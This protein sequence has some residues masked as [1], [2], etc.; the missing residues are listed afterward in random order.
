MRKYCF[1]IFIIISFHSFSQIIAVSGNVQDSISKIPVKYSTVTALR[2]KDLVLIKMTQTNEK[3]YFLLNNI[4]HVNP[5]QIIISAMG[6][7]DKLI[8]IPMN[9]LNKVIDFDTILLSPKILQLDEV[10]IY[11]IKNAVYY[12]HDTLNF[13]ADSFK[14]RQNANVEDLL[15][16]LPGI[17][18]NNQGKITSQGS[19][20]DKVLV[21]GDEFFGNDATIATR[22]L[23]ANGIESIQ[24]YEKKDDTNF[25][26]DGENL[27]IINLKLK[28]SAKN[29]GFG[30]VTGASDFKKFYEGT[31]FANR[32][33]HVEKSAIFLAG[34]N[35]PNSIYRENEIYK[36]AINENI[37]NDEL[38][39]DEDWN[40]TNNEQQKEGISKIF[41][42]GVYYSNKLGEKNKIGF[43]Y[44]YA[45]NPIKIL[46]SEKSQFILKDTNYTT[47]NEYSIFQKSENHNIDLKINHKIDS[48]TE[49]D[50]EPKFTL[51]SVSDNNYQE[52]KF[53]SSN[54]DLTSKTD[55][56]NTTNSTN[57]TSNTNFIFRRKFNKSGRLLRIN[58]NAIIHDTKSKGTL[59]SNNIYFDLLKSNDSINQQKINN[60]GARTNNVIL[61]YREPTSKNT[62][63][64]FY[65]NYNYYTGTQS[66]Q[67]NKYING[68]YSLSDSLLTNTFKSK[69][70]LNDFGLKY[71]HEKNRQLFDI[72]ARFRHLSI[73]NINVITQN[74]VKQS[75]NKI[76][77]YL[78]YRYSFNE[79]SHFNFNYSSSSDQPTIAILQPVNDNSNPNHIIVGNPNL[80]PTFNQTFNISFDKFNDST[81][82]FLY[83]NLSISPI[84]NDFATYVI[85][86]S[87]GRTIEKTINTN[88][89]YNSNFA[90]N[91]G[92]PFFSHKLELAP[93]I[94]LAYFKNTNYINNQKNISTIS[95]ANSGLNFIITLE[96]LVLNVGSNFG[97]NNP[98]STLNNNI[99][100]PYFSQNYSASFKL[101]LP[102][103]IT[104]ESD[105]NYNVNNRRA[106]GYNIHYIIWNASLSKAFFKKENFILSIIG[107]DIL[108]QNINA[109]RD[110]YNNV[111]TDIKTNLIRRFFLLKLVYLLN[112]TGSNEN[113]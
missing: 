2:I 74:Q 48:L 24:V 21:D 42:S 10:A 36:N 28:E 77:P 59:K 33:K 34:G 32:F 102:K 60:G 108:N 104:I 47:T 80:L 27:K 11:A 50:I 52:T 69:K 56:N 64:E 85:Y 57:N 76:L 97:Y 19:V 58:Y 70:I 82:K 65:Y 71:I 1:L 16:K 67:T 6:Y 106:N 45:N 46:R 79:N 20:I 9:T 110:I 94:N 96:A 53:I 107:N 39:N 14:V 61:F 22:N 37:S 89:N 75:V 100:T 73:N 112:K 81:G 83:S 111:I 43:N 88:G 8:Y 93:N 84:N 113:H 87:L 63:L 7:N 92:F 44:A 105:I 15:K 3:G 13:T 26:K 30:K 78:D 35:T 31:A 18:V 55:I 103:M 62:Y 90:I 41:N 66:K 51:I 54:N 29:G 86:D 68:E 25:K 91:A 5:I 38:T 101:Q 49:F 99:N 12:N 72:G 95:T 23:I 98:T 109:S 40:S 17:K 4:H